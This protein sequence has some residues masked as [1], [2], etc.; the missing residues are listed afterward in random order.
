MIDSIDQI[1]IHMKDD[2]TYVWFSLIPTEKLI[3]N[4]NATD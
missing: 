1:I 3:T 2:N 4:V